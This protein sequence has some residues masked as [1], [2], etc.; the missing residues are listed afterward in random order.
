MLLGVG[1]VVV[2]VVALV[3]VAFFT[4][5]M[6]VR[7]TTIDGAKGVQSGEI[8]HAAD[9]P[10]GTPLLRVDTR[11]VAQR[12]A[13]IASIESARVQREYPSSLRITVVERRP[14]ARVVDSDKVHILDRTGVSY[15]TYATKGLPG[16]FAALPVFTTPNPG[17]SDPTTVAAMKATAGLPAEISEQ[18]VAVD[19]SSPV[20]IEFTLKGN[21]KVV[22]GDSARGDEK[23]RT[24][25]YLL[26]RKA[27]E[28]NVSSPDFP[29]YK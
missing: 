1:A 11:V 7:N 18:L 6:S 10:S 25:G 2:I 29:A 17:P 22:W 5:L 23:A 8:L 19:A 14:T 4:P 13:A 3:L 24:L 28:Y 9:V 15:L 20:D 12:V 21:R 27:S 26:S 16:E